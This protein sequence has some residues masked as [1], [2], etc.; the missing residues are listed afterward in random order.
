MLALL[1]ALRSLQ[2]DGVAGGEAR[3]ELVNTEPDL[4][5]DIESLAGDIR[6]QLFS[7][8]GQHYIRSSEYPFYFQ[9]SAFDFDRLTGIDFVLMS[10]GE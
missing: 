8:E 1:G 10:G 6:L 9:L 2:V 3:Q 4:I 5:L 7:L